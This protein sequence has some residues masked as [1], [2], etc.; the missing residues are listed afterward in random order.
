MTL[1]ALNLEPPEEK[2]TQAYLKG[3]PRGLGMTD[4]SAKWEVSHHGGD[5]PLPPVRL[6][7]V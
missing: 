4:R 7:T 1:T 5:E 6:P 2:V 3:L